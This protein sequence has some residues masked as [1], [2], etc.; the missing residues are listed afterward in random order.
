MSRAEMR[1]KAR[2]EAKK[3]KV[4][5]LTQ[6]QIDRIKED[7]SDK[8]VNEM[9][10]TAFG[11]MLS[12]PTNVLARCYWEKSASKRIPQFLEECVS[13]YDS[14]SSG[15]ITLSELIKDTED[16]SGMTIVCCERLKGLCDTAT[17]SK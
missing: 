4:Y 16:L 6:E 11:L 14:V 13:L 2:G 7:A 5:T 15:V 10:S 3:S 1:R 12:I 9:L 8:A 17:I